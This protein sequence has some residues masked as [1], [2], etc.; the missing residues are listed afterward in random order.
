M[1]FQVT[2]TAS[3][4]IVLKTKIVLAD[5]TLLLKS[6]KESKTKLENYQASSN[7][8]PQLILLSW[9]CTKTIQNQ[10]VLILMIVGNF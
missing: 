9:V 10:I 5:L 6:V 3:L 4:L 7:I 2:Q 1:N 8:N